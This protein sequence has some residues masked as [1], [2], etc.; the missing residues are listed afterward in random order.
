MLEEGT[1]FLGDNRRIATMPKPLREALH[2]AGW[3]DGKVYWVYDETSD[4]LKLVRPEKIM[5]LVKNAE[6]EF[7]TR[8]ISPSSEP[9]MPSVAYYNIT[10]AKGQGP[11]YNPTNWARSRLVGARA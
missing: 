7:R 8:S 6:R 1:I 2:A 11:Y 9:P 5:Q 4:S 3:E 10:E